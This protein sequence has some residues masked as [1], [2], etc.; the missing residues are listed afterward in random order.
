MS[1]EA[2]GYDRYWTY[3]IGPFIGMEVLDEGAYEVVL[4]PGM[5][6]SREP[7][8]APPDG[9]RIAFEDDVIV[10][11]DGFRWING[12][13]PIEIDDIEAMLAVPSSLRAFAG[14]RER[15]C[16]FSS[17]YGRGPRRSA[18]SHSDLGGA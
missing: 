9:P 10:T 3:G 8:V 2:A 6:L 18:R 15:Q 4:Q 11:E 17:R 14:R 1:A 16:R 13:M 7:G 5:A 12:A